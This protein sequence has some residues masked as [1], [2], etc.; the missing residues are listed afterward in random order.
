MGNVHAP[1]V[2]AESNFLQ[3]ERT[4]KGA[5]GKSFIRPRQPGENTEKLEAIWKKRKEEESTGTMEQQETRGQSSTEN[6]RKSGEEDEDDEIEDDLELEVDQDKWKRFT[7]KHGLH[8]RA[9]E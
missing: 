7:E 1:D 2:G 3:A 6:W 5:H 8:L 9:G 4:G